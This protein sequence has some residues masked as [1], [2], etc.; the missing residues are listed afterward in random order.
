MLVEHQ[1]SPDPLM[2]LRVLDY[3]TRIWWRH[4]D[5]R[6]GSGTGAT[7]RRGGTGSSVRLPIVLPVVVYQGRRRWNVPTSLAG[8]YGPV[9]EW[10]L[11]ALLPRHEF[12]LHDLT[13][14]SVEELLAAP[15]TP[16][17]R[18]A[19]AML[20]FAPRQEHLA[21]VL[22]EFTP[23]VLDLVRTRADRMFA[24]IMEYA[25]QVSDTE[26][27]ELQT[28]F[29]QLGPD[30]QEAYMSTTLERGVAQGVAKGRA[31]GAAHMLT[32]LLVQRF[33]PPTPE[34]TER[35]QAATPEELDA[36]VDRLPGAASIDD[37][38]R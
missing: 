16:A 32:R 2:A 1:S 29:H 19:L 17:A 38:L 35:I 10:E 22:E 34:Q 18:L 37:V 20:R 3:V 9:G 8:L 5:A 26:P 28:F 13:G 14:V 27:E 15:L 33:G 36:W 21:Q 30:A 12:V 23:D 6:V 31:E 24:T 7:R 4:L 25:Y 11:G